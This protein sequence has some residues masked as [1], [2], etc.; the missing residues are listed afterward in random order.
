MNRWASHRGNG[1]FDQILGIA[2]TAMNIRKPFFCAILISL[3]ATS[4]FAAATPEIAEALLR[5][6]TKS[7]KVAKTELPNEVGFLEKTPAFIHAAEVLA[8]NAPESERK[9]LSKL[10]EHVILAEY[11][12]L[13]ISPSIMETCQNCLPKTFAD[14]INGRAIDLI[15][16]HDDLLVTISAQTDN[17]LRLYDKNGKQI[18]SQAEYRRAVDEMVEIFAPSM[19]DAKKEQTAEGFSRKFVKALKTNGSA[20]IEYDSKGNALSATFKY[21]ASKAK[22]ANIDLGKFLSNA[23][24]FLFGGGLASLGYKGKDKE[25][26]AKA[27]LPVSKIELK[28]IE[29]LHRMS[30]AQRSALLSDADAEYLVAKAHQIEAQKK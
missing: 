3:C 1:D 13:G 21:G 16:K 11:K 6:M 20:E 26:E 28:R 9:R 27:A 19:S 2:I 4:A 8:R 23:K 15:N 17:A 14:N 22:V 24:Y 30:E 25:P 10:L 29:L 12:K 7:V 5:I 18:S